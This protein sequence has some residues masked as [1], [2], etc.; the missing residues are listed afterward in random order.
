VRRRAKTLA[1]VFVAV[2]VAGGDSL[3]RADDV[4]GVSLSALA[5]YSLAQSDADGATNAAGIGVGLRA[6]YTFEN[7]LALGATVVR[8]FGHPAPLAATVARADLTRG[9]IAY[10]GLEPGYDI[11]LR[12]TFLRPSFLVLR[13]YLGVGFQSHF[14]TYEPSPGAQVSGSEGAFFTVWPGANLSLAIGRL[15]VGI[16]ARYVIEAFGVLAHGPSAFA[17][18]GVHFE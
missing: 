13:P 1:Y 6:S 12:P 4:S 18:V 2:I 8:H 9:N 15:R 11:Q 16:D 5:G 10:Y 17:T 14:A 3:A 7:H